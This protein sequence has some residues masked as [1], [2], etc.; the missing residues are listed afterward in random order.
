MLQGFLQI[1]EGM[2]LRIQADEQ[3]G[4]FAIVLRFAVDANET[5]PMC[6]VFN[7]SMML[8]KTAICCELIFR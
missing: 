5:P 8:A 4:E 6:Q 3:V 2:F 1:D 7:A